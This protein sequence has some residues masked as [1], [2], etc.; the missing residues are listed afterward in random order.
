[1]NKIFKILICLYLCVFLFACG[2]EYADTNGADNYTLQTITDSNIIN[3][4]LGASGLGYKE[5]N[6][7]GVVFSNEYYS[8]NFNGVERIYNT[9]FILPSDVMIYIGYLTVDSGNFRMVIVN[10]DKIIY[11][12][13]S[14][15][16]NEML[17]FDNL[18]G[19]FSIHLAGESA[20]FELN[21]EVQ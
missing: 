17:R 4:E 6:I 16:F 5:Q 2:E 14:G 21:L 15:T 7:A 8:K 19:N 13:E 12:V 10:D 9:N 11:D 1:M 3:L 20:D 18:K